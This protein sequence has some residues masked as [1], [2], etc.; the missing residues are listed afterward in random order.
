MAVDEVTTDIPDHSH[1]SSFWD[2]RARGLGPMHSR[3]ICTAGEE[4]ALC[5]TDDWYHDEDILLHEF[6]HGLHLLGLRYS[7]PSFDSRLKAVYD[8]AKAKGLWKSTH[9]ISSANEYFV[10]I[11]VLYEAINDEKHFFSCFSVFY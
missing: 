5:L 9:A 3:P 1:L 6:A 8:S 7:I 10:S 4:N 11:Y 2:T